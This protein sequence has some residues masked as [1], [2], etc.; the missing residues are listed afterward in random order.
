MSLIV[1]SP[2][3]NA[4]KP[5]LISLLMITPVDRMYLSERTDVDLFWKHTNIFSHML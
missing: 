2:N 1:K 4:E 3:T 5:L